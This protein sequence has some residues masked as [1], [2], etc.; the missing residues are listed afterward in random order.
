MAKINFGEP[1]RYNFINY[2][3]ELTDSMEHLWHAW[4]I[5]REVKDRL[6]VDMKELIG[7]LGS[8]GRAG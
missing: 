5:M 6:K 1:F 8:E 7:V 4:K 2:F 3:Y